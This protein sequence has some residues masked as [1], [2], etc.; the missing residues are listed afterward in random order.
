MNGKYMKIRMGSSNAYLVKG[1]EGYLLIDAGVKGKIN[2]LKN[3]M[4]EYDVKF[5]D[6]KLII[7]THVHYDHVGN[8]KEIKDKS[9]APVLVHQKEADLLANGDSHF[10]AGNNLLGKLIAKTAGTAVGGQNSFESVQPDIKIKDYYNL[11]GFG[12]DGDILHTPGH[13]AGSI[14][15]IIDNRH[16][17]VGDTM[18][19]LIPYT[20][21]PPFADDSTKLIESWEKIASSDCKFF[22]PGH[23]YLFHRNKFINT[24]K[25]KRK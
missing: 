19:S 17:F 20:I 13:S 25:R 2:K 6:I 18:F 8:L 5:D 1:K 14:T 9:K 7:I 24:L 10:P 15:V 23:G 4:A 22:Y 11:K 3:K 16:C 12:F 21:N